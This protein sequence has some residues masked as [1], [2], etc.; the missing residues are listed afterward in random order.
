MLQSLQV[1]CPNCNE[2]FTII[3]PASICTWLNPDLVSQL[4]KPEGFSQK[5]EKCEGRIV[6]TGRILVNAPT[7]MFWIDIGL[8]MESRKRILLRH[9]V[10]DRDGTILPFGPLAELESANDDNGQTS[11][12]S[13]ATEPDYFV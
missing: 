11:K 8:D 1:V 12:D 9:R 2:Q 5:C 13:V 3:Y 7:G 4:L 10:I 6:L